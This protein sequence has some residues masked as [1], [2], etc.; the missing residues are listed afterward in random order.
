MK[1]KLRIAFVEEWPSLRGTKILPYLAEQF[2]L[3]YITSDMGT[4]PKAD[5]AD[6]KLFPAVKYINQ[7]GLAFSRL[8]DRLYAEGRIDFAVHYAGIAFLSRKT[9]IVGVLGGSYCTDFLDSWRGA[10]PLRKARLVVGFLHYTVPEFLACRRADR[11]VANSEG[12]KRELMGHYGLKGKPFDVVYNGIDPD[13]TAMGAVKKIGETPRAIYS[14]RL[15]EKKGILGVVKALH[16]RRD[17]DISLRIA[18]EGPDR[19]AIADIGRKDSRIRLLG[20]VSKNK[21]LQ[22]MENTNLFVF[23]SFH[24]GCPNALL[25]A[26][27]ARHACVC[28]GIAPVREVLGDSGVVTEVGDPAALCEELAR[29]A[30]EPAEMV[31]LSGKAYEKSLDFSWEK[32]A[33]Q[34]ES[35]LRAFHAQLG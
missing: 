8:V 20:H 1:K 22:E 14:G 25:E 29:L 11:L 28:Y 12:L 23:P 15:H 9:P 17:I 18:G 5:F 21:L 6:V 32:C 26:M 30:K 10:S 13:F 16:R 34:F 27:A 31:S 24:E 4:F 2:E 35:I 19:A 7:R 33:K 3:T